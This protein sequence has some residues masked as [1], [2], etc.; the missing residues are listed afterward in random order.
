MQQALH[1]SPWG[2]GFALLALLLFWLAFCWGMPC[3]LRRVRFRGRVLLAGVG[4]LCVLWGHVQYPPGVVLDIKNSEVGRLRLSGDDLSARSATIGDYL[5]GMLLDQSGPFISL[6]LPCLRE[7]D[8]LTQVGSEL[9]LAWSE[10]VSVTEYADLAA[11]SD[12]VLTGSRK[13]V[14]LI[15]VESLRADVIGAAGQPK[16]IMPQVEALVETGWHFR[17]HYSSSSHSSYADITAISGI[18][19]FW[20]ERIHLYP[21]SVSHPRPRI[22]DLLSSIG[23]RTAIFSSQN[24]NWGGMLRY[25]ESEHLDVLY[26]ADDRSYGSAALGRK[27]SLNGGKGFDA[28]TLE[29]ALH[30]MS[31]E[32][33]PFFAYLNL[34][35]SHYPYYFPEGLPRPFGEEMDVSDLNFLNLPPEL[36]PAM[37]LRYQDSLHYL[38]EQ[39]GRLVAGLKAAGKWDD[40]LLIVTGDTGQAFGEHGV[41]GHARDLYEEVVRTPLMIAGVDHAVK[42]NA[43]A[44]SQHADIAPTVLDLLGLP[45]YEGFQ[46]TS[47]L[48]EPR[49]WLPLV[50]Q[51]P[52]LKQIALVTEHH[53]LLYNWETKQARFYNLEGGPGKVYETLADAE[54]DCAQ[55][56]LAVLQDWAYQQTNYYRNPAR[57]L[58]FFAPQYSNLITCPKQPHHP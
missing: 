40:T 12:L 50:C 37:R 14:I 48:Q 52:A 57:V 8:H 49:S 5:E 32:D 54:S 25:L 47:L 33:A 39:I 51:S 22:Y 43:A 20:G 38:D 11:K 4:L 17:N 21:A 28:D 53:K 30:W 27:L 46:G 6:T 34:Q 29:S 24:E 45:R 36:I 41:T 10:R 26:H 58:Q 35:G 3:L 9:E 7:S 18:Y 13:N 15:L 42:V 31:E 2:T 56:L 1:F 55:R 19:P 23:Y 16:G 44:L